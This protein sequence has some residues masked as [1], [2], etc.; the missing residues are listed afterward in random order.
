MV[1]IEGG[2]KGYTLIC[3]TAGVQL[4][5]TT[6]E[7][8]TYLANKNGSSEVSYSEGEK[9]NQKNILSWV[10]GPRPEAIRIWNTNIA[11]SVQSL[12]ETKRFRFMSCH[13]TLFQHNRN[14]MFAPALTESF[15]SERLVPNRI[16]VLID[17]VYDVYKRLSES[18]ENALWFEADAEKSMERRLLRSAGF[19]D[20]TREFSNEER[21]LNL[22]ITRI[23]GIQRLIAW[24]RSEMQFAEN[25]AAQLG[26]AELYLIAVKHPMSVMEQLL[27]QNQPPVATYVSHPIA[28]LKQQF[29]ETGGEEWPDYVRRVTE[30]PIRLLEH[31]GSV[32]GISPTTID[33]SRF[34]P[35]ER[36][37][38]HMRT[39]GMTKRWPV[40]TNN[41]RINDSNAVTDDKYGYSDDIFSSNVAISS[42]YVRTLN[43][44]LSDEV[45]FRDHY[46]IVHTPNLLLYQPREDGLPISAGV[47]YEVDHF[48]ELADHG[49]SRKM[50]AVHDIAD[51]HSIMFG[52]ERSVDVGLRRLSLG[53]AC[54][55]MN[56]AAVESRVQTIN[57]RD[58]EGIL[59]G[60]EPVDSFLGRPIP[61]AVL[62]SI[63]NTGYHALACSY[64]YRT[65]T[66]L[67]SVR[68]WALVIIADL[69]SNGYLPLVGE[70]LRTGR[71]ADARRL[72]GTGACAGALISGLSD[73]R[74]MG[75]IPLEDWAREFL[76]EEGDRRAR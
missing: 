14:V 65:L 52:D 66:G 8:A 2:P 76:V 13:L 22:G 47:G 4:S 5:K 26:V 74:Q 53:D 60:V 54:I 69:S 35:P 56:G 32:V 51:V 72:C 34:K 12:D 23:T 64:L 68:D 24:R 37:H 6:V 18:G 7:I 45:P 58:A 63:K 49:S 28:R 73:V 15:K 70:W 3:G 44:M 9:E 41:R 42:G 40:H 36:E 1:E 17:D 39:G 19:E 57:E 30:L 38:V 27:N 62:A 11:D 61:D 33:E 46:I 59:K 21:L 20:G 16:V 50:V 29:E 31:A 48:A 43:A 10:V 25:L 71:T 75:S 67:D 55:A